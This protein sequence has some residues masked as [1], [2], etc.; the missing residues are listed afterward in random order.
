MDYL[1]V[2]DEE[3]FPQG[4]KIVQ[5]NRHGSWIWVILEGVVDVVKETPDG[6]L[7]LIKLGTG[8]F[9]GS[10][11]SFLFHDNIR[12]ASAH[13]STDVQLGVLDTPRL[14]EEYAALSEEF[15]NFIMSLETGEMRLLIKP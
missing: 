1:Y 13:A 3:T 5:E 10:V 15:K 8:S 14:A 12:K 11:A 9:I 6:P 4:Y 7:T 2:L